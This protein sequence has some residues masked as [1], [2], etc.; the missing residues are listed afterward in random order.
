[1]PKSLTFLTSVHIHCLIYYN[2]NDI[3]IKI[4][5]NSFQCH[6]QY[7]CIRVYILLHIAQ[8]AWSSCIVSAKETGAS[9][10]RSNPA[11]V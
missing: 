3:E 7:I 5:K 8:G 10:V 1:L 4:A 9:V 2:C 6:C 11:R